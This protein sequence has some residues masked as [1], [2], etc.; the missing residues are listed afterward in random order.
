MAQARSYGG[1]YPGG[2]PGYPA[3]PVHHYP[4]YGYPYYSS[5][6]YGY[7]Y[8]CGSFGIGVSIGFGYGYPYY[9]G[10]PYGAWYG[11]GYW[12][13]GPGYWGAPYAPVFVPVPYGVG[14]EEGRSESR[15]YSSEQRPTGSLRFRADPG[16]ARI[17][18]DGALAGTVDDFDGFSNHLRLEAGRHHI[19]LRADGYEPYS[20]EIMVSAGRTLTAR[21]NLK[22]TAR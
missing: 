9:G 18:V 19:E 10:Y 13:Y 2:Y 22:P 12:P 20:A 7:P 14:V 6:G 3:Y 4:Y 5:F 21:A 1:G 16:S 15:E 8:C 11:P 17:Y